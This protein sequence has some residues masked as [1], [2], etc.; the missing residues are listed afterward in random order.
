METN[1]RKEQLRPIELHAM[2][3]ADA[4][5]RTARKRGTNDLHHGFSSANALKDA[6][7][8]DAFG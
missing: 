8:A 7:R 2:R 1:E 3:D 6:I 4:A 5:D